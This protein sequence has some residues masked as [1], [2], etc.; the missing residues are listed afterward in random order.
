[1]QGE[2]ALLAALEEMEG[3]IMA[4]GWVAMEGDWAEEG[5]A[6]LAGVLLDPDE[7]KAPVVA[8]GEVLLA[9][10]AE[11]GRTSLGGKDT[12]HLCS[13]Q[14]CVK[15]MSKR[16]GPAGEEHWPILVQSLRHKSTYLLS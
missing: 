8:L 16:I 11:E 14:V 3:E 12:M 13:V 1:M 9:R 5:L 10:G 6:A 15:Q 4:E 7:E 2:E